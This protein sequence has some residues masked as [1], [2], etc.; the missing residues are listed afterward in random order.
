MLFRNICIS[1]LYYKNRYF[2]EYDSTSVTHVC[3]RPDT[4]H[5]SIHMKTIVLSLF[6]NWS[7]FSSSTTIYNITKIFQGAVM[8]LV[9]IVW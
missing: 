5:S 1:L 7:V 2:Y 3:S 9:M 4:L 6:Y 8:V